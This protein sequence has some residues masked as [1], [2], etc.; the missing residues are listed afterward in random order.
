MIFAVD[1]NCQAASSVREPAKAAP[2]FRPVRGTRILVV[3]FQGGKQADGGM[4]SLTQLLERYQGLTVTVLSQADTPKTARWRRA[5]WKVLI[6]PLGYQPGGRPEHRALGGLAR[7][8]QHLLWNVRTAWLALSERIE[9]AHVNDPHALWHVIAGLR[10]LG[11]PTIYNIRDT[12]PGFSSRDILKWRCAFQLTQSQIVLSREMREF[13]QRALAVRGRGLR[14][15]YSVVDFQRMHPVP[16]VE[17]Q[18]L[19]ARL[20]LPGGFVAGYV[21]SFSEKKAQL[22]F[23]EEAGQRLKHRA[24]SI[25]VYFLGDFDPQRDAY[26]AA[27]ERSSRELGLEARFKFKGYADRMERW[28]PALDA[29]IV[30]TQNEGLARC[31]IES[32]ACG[33]PVVSFDVCS[34][35]EILEEQGCGLVV[36]R[37]DYAG[38]VAALSNLAEND[39]VRAR[40]SRRGAIVARNKFDETR[41]VAGYAAVYETLAARGEV[42]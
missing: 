21:A 39:E 41:N 33:T 16:E 1:D 28:Y 20:G 25:H 22:R 14:A 32:L 23:I 3:A 6:W 2:G 13:W 9:V 34:A 12:K 30:A 35:R 11:I 4:E 40:F 36:P 38:L 18:E 19:R 27:C 5:G 10:L 8:W 26:A 24:P 7:V 42:R 15:I 17:R 31:M 29:V 37:G